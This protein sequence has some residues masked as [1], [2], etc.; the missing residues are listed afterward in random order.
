VRLPCDENVDR[1]YVE[2]FRSTDWI[3][4]TKVREALSPDATDEGIAEFATAAEWVVFTGDDDFLRADPDCGVVFYHRLERPS[5]GDVV[6]A[7]QAI[8]EAYAE[9][10]E[11]REFVPGGWKDR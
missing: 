6:N 2:T 3:T 8:E 5:P 9:S 7:L 4:V 11:I 10:D 1:R